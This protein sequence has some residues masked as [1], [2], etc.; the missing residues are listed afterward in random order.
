MAR[1][2]FISKSLS[3]SEKFGALVTRLP[4][5]YEF[6]HTLYPLLVIHTDDYGRLQ[7]D[8]YTVKSMC[9]PA[10]L[11]TLDEFAAA[12]TGLDAIA[13]I[14]WYQAGPKRYV[15][16]VDFDAHQQGLHKRT[17]AQI[18]PPNGQ[19]GAAPVQPDSTHFPEIPGSSRKFR[20]KR[21]EEKGSEGKR[22]EVKKDE[23]RAPTGRA[24]ES[25]GGVHQAQ[26]RRAA[27]VAA[28]RRAAPPVSRSTV[29]PEQAALLRKHGFGGRK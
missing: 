10:S 17:K 11:R 5:T 19:A 9:Y 15:Q 4:A 21:S 29:T 7:G 16:I 26:R 23:E 3:T 14:R 22:R 27:P 8:P 20:V 24:S 18:P 25:H 12:L 13:L 28:G 1:G 6:L 2:R